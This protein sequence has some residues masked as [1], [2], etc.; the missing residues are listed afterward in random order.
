MTLIYRRK[1]SLTG[2]NTPNTL[3][4][5]GEFNILRH[6]HIAWDRRNHDHECKEVQPTPVLYDSSQSHTL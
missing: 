3:Q 6:V 4:D 2:R 5:F 1:K